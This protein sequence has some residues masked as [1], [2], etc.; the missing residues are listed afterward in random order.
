M[1]NTYEHEID[2][3]DLIFYILKRWRYI[4]FIAI[5]LAVL[6]GGFKLCKGILKYQDKLYMAELQKNYETD[7][8]NYRVTNEGYKRNIKTLTQNIDYEELYEK[9]SVLFQLNPYSKWVAKTQLFV[10]MDEENDLI[11]LVDPTDSL[12]KAYCSI[13]NSE[14]SLEEVSKENAIE[15]KYLRELINIQGDYDGNM[16]TISVAYKDGEGAQKILDGILKSISTSRLNLETSFGAHSIIFLNSEKGMMADQELAERQNKRIESLS[17]MHKSLEEIQLALDNQ[18]EP[19][20]PTD[21]SSKGVFKSAFKYGVI[22]GVFGVFFAAFFLCVIYATNSKL[23]S[24]DEFISRFGIKVFG[25]FTKEE[26]K[27]KFSGID[28]W[29]NKIEGKQAFSR[30]DVLKRIIASISLFTEKNQVILLTGTVEIDLLK[31]IE[32]ELKDNFNKLT[33]EVGA[34]MNRN[35]ETLTKLPAIDSVVLVEKCGVS[36]YKDIQSQVETIYSLN[37]S[38]IGCIIL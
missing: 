38:I 16:I 15:I 11:T 30:E 13:L 18:K 28:K 32:S 33:F 1:D 22:G 21:M 7:L 14:G 5:V 25:T 37:K 31:N 23:R 29:L 3:K 24:G 6:M 20:I 36:K 26:R 35:P 8:K 19:Q 17:E 34:D 2:L 4:F 27:R 12:V 9:N 10:K